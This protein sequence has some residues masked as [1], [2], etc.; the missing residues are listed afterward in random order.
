[1]AN[2]TIYKVR[3]RHGMNVKVLK[4]HENHFIGV[5]VELNYRMRRNGKIAY[6]V[7]VTNLRTG[8]HYRIK[9]FSRISD[10]FYKYKAA[11]A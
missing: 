1:M 4:E 8:R 7:V 5:R 10:A 2:N 6:A 9:Q 11:I 3:G